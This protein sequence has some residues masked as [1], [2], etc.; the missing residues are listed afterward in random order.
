MQ[1]DVKFET[2]VP[3]YRGLINRRTFLLT[4]L[5]L[6]RA[7]DR[8]PNLVLIVASGWRGQATPWDGDADL[9]TPNLEKFGKESIV[10]S[11]TYCASPKPD[12]AQTALLTSKFPHAAKKDD[13]ALVRL[14][15]LTPDAAITAFEKTPFALQI[16]FP[17]PQDLREPGVAHLHV[18]GNVA[19]SDDLPA[20][21][22]LAKFYGR[23]AAIDDDLGRIFAALDRLNLSQNTLV[24][25]TSD[26][27]QQIGSQGLDGNGVPFEESVRIPLAI[28]Y[29][30]K[31]KPDARD[32]A[33]QVDI[34]PTLLSLCGME[35]PEGAQGQDLFGKTPPEVAFAEGTFQGDWRMLVRGYDKV[36]ATSKGEV[37]HL[38][39]LA[40]DPYEMTDLA[41][42]SAQKLKLASL[43]AQLA[44][45]MQ[46]LGDGMDPSGLRKRKSSSAR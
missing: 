40:E 13:Q 36:I 29:P 5:A 19:S 44:A 23:C 9:A 25:F 1:F 28:R 12:L 24:V 17:D 45:Q 42:D 8:P 6:S 43:K 2:Q 26:C 4:P 15:T 35:I 34:M 14:K 46:K 22:D 16:T 27:G 7:A 33:S 32:L 21:Q 3:Y 10:F 11:R 38:F 20:R 37:T 18:R 39:N 31:L 41:R 30:S